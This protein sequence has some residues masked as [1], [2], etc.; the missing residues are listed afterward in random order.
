MVINKGDSMKKCKEFCDKMKPYAPTILR[1]VVGIVFLLHGYGK[2]W[3][4]APGIENW[5]GM[6]TG[7]GLPF[8]VLMAWMVGLIEF[9]GGIAL[10]IGFGTSIASFLLAIVMGVAVL[11]VHLGN[12]FFN[13]AGGY[14]F[15][16]TLFAANL[17]LMFSGAGAMS[18]DS[19]CCKKEKK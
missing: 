14:E 19:K 16:L 1:V 7:M 13:S 12:G 11:K 10:I 6:L 8:P 5:I 2:L 18:L 17:S 9:L 4:A 15:A 3:G